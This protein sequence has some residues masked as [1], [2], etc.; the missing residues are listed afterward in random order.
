MLISHN[1]FHYYGEGKVLTG[2]KP[3]TKS[4]RCMWSGGIAPLHSY[5]QH[6]LYLQTKLFGYANYN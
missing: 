1:V 3:I 5:Q 2:V 6:F 4:C